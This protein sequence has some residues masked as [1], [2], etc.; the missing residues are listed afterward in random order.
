VTGRSTAYGVVALLLWSSTVAFSRSAAEALHGL[1]VAGI[2]SL[3]AG[4]IG[5]AIQGARGELG[6]L[7]R[8]SRRYLFVCGGLFAAY[9]V[10]FYGALGLAH[11][12]SDVVAVAVLNYLWPALTLALA[13]PILGRR[14]AWTLWPGLL[15]AAGGAALVTAPPELSGA[16]DLQLAH[17]LAA[18]AAVTWALYSNLTRKLGGGQSVNP[19]PLFFLATAA[20]TLP[21]GLAASAPWRW[22]WPLGVEL[23]YLTL[24]PSLLAYVLWD[25]GMRQ[26]DAARLA[27]LANL[28]PVAATAFAA[29]YLDIAVSGTQLVGVAVVV[30]GVLL[31][32]RAS[33]DK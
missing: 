5:L 31:C 22:S 27:A 13:V 29:S 6:A 23:A 24:F 4:V 8:S 2:T 32:D 15:L 33:R 10:L 1:L 7:R 11:H 12:R 14:V 21:L 16:W 28:T 30:I 3:G 17:L 19:V 25:H 26:G 18:L 9:A 20:V